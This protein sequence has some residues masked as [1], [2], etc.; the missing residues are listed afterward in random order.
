[1]GQWERS[2]TAGRK[3]N[4]DR[5][6]PHPVQPNLHVPSCWPHLLRETCLHLFLHPFS[7]RWP[8]LHQETPI[9]CIYTVAVYASDIYMCA[10]SSLISPTRLWTLKSGLA[11]VR[12]HTPEFLPEDSTSG[13]LPEENEN[14]DSKRYL[15]PYGSLKHYLQQPRYGN[16]LSV[17]HRWMDKED[18]RYRE[19]ENGK[20]LNPKKKWNLAICDNIDG[21]REHCAKWNKS[22]GES[23]I[24]WFH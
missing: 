20:L 13:Y 5:P 1:M 15:H 14:T 11:Q 12:L 21:P 9:T 19:R 23:H 6:L 8:F 24:L 16:N 3:I 18:V 10:C 7:N 2:Y 4:S 17:H 22:D